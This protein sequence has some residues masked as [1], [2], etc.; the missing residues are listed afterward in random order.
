MATSYFRAGFME[1]AID[2]FRTAW[3]FYR[4]TTDDAP[5]VLVVSRF[6]AA[7]LYNEGRTRES[8]AFL[9]EAVETVVR[10]GD[11]R[12]SD[13]ARL[14]FASYLADSGELAE[15]RV[16]LGGID[17]ALLGDVGSTALFWQTTCRVCALQ[18]DLEGVRRAAAATCAMDDYGD[19]APAMIE[20]L[21]ECGISALIAGETAAARRCLTRALDTC[22]ARGLTAAH[23]DLLMENALERRLGGALEEARTLALRGL[24]LIGEGKLG[25]HR[26]VLAALA[27]GTALDDRE[28]LGYEPDAALMDLVFETALPLIYGPL[29]A[30][31]AQLQAGR[32]ERD[33]ARRLLL[34]AVRSAMAALPMQL[35]ARSCRR[36]A[37]RA[38]RRRRRTRIMH[39]F[40]AKRTGRQSDC[41]P[42]RSDPGAALRRS[43]VGPRTPRGGRVR[44]DRLAGVRS[45]RARSER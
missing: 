32:G 20:A 18:G 19:E 4:T 34:R 42:R 12:T 8:T 41:G 17:P 11:P 22:V 28:L 44:F 31:C 13:R 14:T 45:A 40:A 2:H 38:R 35:P 1:R 21:A 15:T 10:C 36:P 29:A 37:R 30:L 25:R 6:L 39:A 33:D 16:V 27:V 26:A 43:V 5:F 23:G 7:A 24:P 9:R 3:A